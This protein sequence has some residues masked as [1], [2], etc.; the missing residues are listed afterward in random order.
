MPG[1]LGALGLEKPNN[2]RAGA[3]GLFTNAKDL[4]KWDENFYSA[5]IGGK[6]VIAQVQLPGALNNG[7]SLD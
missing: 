2:E 5:R 1:R 4:L 3:G 7:T 6:S